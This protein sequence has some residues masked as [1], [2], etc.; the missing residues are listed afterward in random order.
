M[1]IV[2][3]D[4]DDRV[5][6]VCPAGPV[7]DAE[8]LYRLLRSTDVSGMK[9]K[10]GAFQIQYMMRPPDPVSNVPGAR[11]GESAL[12]RDGRDDGTLIKESKDQSGFA[13]A[14]A[15]VAKVADIR[16]LRSIEQPTQQ[17]FF[18]YEDP[19]EL[20]PHH[21]VIRYTDQGLAPPKQYA[22]LARA[23]LKDVFT[24]IAQSG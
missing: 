17:L 19:T 15:A 3:C 18:V 8:H 6:G 10:D 11:D 21:A 2:W 1:P 24:I 12:R 16:L 22:R 20:C 5:A 7:L 14:G 4:R 13:A 9:L 23:K